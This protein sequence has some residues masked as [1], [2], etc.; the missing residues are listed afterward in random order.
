MALSLFDE[1]GNPRA[2]LV[3]N[4]SGPGLILAYENGQTRAGLT[5]DEDGRPMLIL[6]DENGKT[7]A[8]LFVH[9]DGPVMAVTIC[10]GRK[11][12]FVG[13]FLTDAEKRWIVSELRA[14]LAEIGRPLDEQRNGHSD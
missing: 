2:L 12:Y 5:V 13:S 4:K 1:N 9:E 10:V 14:F 8:M 6:H 7:R 3:V 11:S